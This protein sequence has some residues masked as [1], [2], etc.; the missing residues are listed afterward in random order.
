MSGETA[1]VDHR[2][3]EQIHVSHIYRS[4]PADCVRYRKPPDVDGLL[5]LTCWLT[6]GHEQASQVGILLAPMCT[7]TLSR[8]RIRSRQ[9]PFGSFGGND[10]AQTEQCYP[11]ARSSPSSL[12]IE[13][14]RIV[15]VG[16]STGY[17]I[18]EPRRPHAS[19]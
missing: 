18:Q 1:G 19:Q 4:W 7:A 15:H 8:S 2:L 5:V 6:G 11:R 12:Q 16:L 14:W 9:A 13:V 10:S 3:G 17:G